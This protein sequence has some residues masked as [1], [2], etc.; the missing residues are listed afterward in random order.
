MRKIPLFNAL[1][2]TNGNLNEL[3]QT[4]VNKSPQTEVNKSAFKKGKK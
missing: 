4:K 1:F 2:L 3:A